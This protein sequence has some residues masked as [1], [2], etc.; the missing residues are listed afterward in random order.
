MEF[1]DIEI[2]ISGCDYNVAAWHYE[3]S[4]SVVKSLAHIASQHDE[5]ESNDELTSGIY[6][7]LYDATKILSF[8]CGAQWEISD[9]KLISSKGSDGVEELLVKYGV[10]NETKIQ[11]LNRLN[12]EAIL[13]ILGLLKNNNAY[14]ARTLIHEILYKLHSTNEKWEKIKS[15]TEELTMN[16]IDWEAYRDKLKRILDSMAN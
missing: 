3:K 12:Q 8:S 2:R 15:L 13:D 6:K 16:D 10:I 1:E 9:P 5:P 7:A 14:E 11:K 4:L